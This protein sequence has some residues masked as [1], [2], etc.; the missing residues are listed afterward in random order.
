MSREFALGQALC[1]RAAMERYKREHTSFEIEMLSG[2]G[3][4]L[5]SS[6]G[7]PFQQNGQITDLPCLA[8]SRQDRCHG[9]FRRYKDS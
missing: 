1:N 7:F 5:L 6:P 4:C 9:R 3:E 8:G 2:L